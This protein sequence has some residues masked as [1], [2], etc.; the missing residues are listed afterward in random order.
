[1]ATTKDQ[2][3]EWLYVAK[4]DG[5]THMLVVC[6]TFEYEDYPV[7][8]YPDEDLAE[9]AN[10]LYDENMQKV[11]ECYDLSTDM[12]AQLAEPRAWNGWRP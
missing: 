6:D 1:M 8:V 4:S 3:R 7:H 10:R 5:A 11:M 2:I 12:E 9:K